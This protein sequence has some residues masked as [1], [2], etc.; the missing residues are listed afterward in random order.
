MDLTGKLGYALKGS[1]SQICR[2]CHSLEDDKDGALYLWV[3]KE[4]VSGEKIDC[5]LCHMFTRP[6]R[7]LSKAIIHDN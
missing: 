7:G 2:Q 3:H 6:E 4:H 5:S 1:R